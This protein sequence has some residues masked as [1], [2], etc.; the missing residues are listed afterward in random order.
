MALPKKLSDEEFI[1]DLKE[2]KRE[3]IFANNDRLILFVVNFLQSNNIEPTFDKIVVA[4]FKLFPKKFSL[5][6]FA[7]FPDGKRINDCLLH[8]AH[9]TKGWLSGNAQSGFRLTDKGRYFL[10]ETNKILDGKI[11]VTKKYEIV[12]RRKELTFINLLKQTT[13]YKKYEEGKK[14]EITESE[15]FE[16]LRVEP[17]SKSSIEPNLKKYLDY[18]IR[19]GDSST[20]DFLEFIKI[21]LKGD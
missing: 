6:G 16:A 11:N 21:R 3:Y 7:E 12:P 13:A 17:T 4:A 5:I 10:D 8:C 19:I 2:F 18:A 15:I 9:K 1:R 20:K 14:D